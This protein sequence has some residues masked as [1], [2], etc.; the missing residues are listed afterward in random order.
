M[1]DENVKSNTA[2]EP[3]API[4]GGVGG[5]IVLLVI[6]VIGLIYMKRRRRKPL[7]DRVSGEN[8]ALQIVDRNVSLR[9]GGD[10]QEGMYINITRASRQSSSDTDDAI[11]PRVST[12]DISTD[13]S[14]T[15]Y[16]N[17]NILTTV[18]IE[19]LKDYIK[20]K[21]VNEGFHSEYKVIL[22]G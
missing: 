5:G 10:H 9:H 3:V 18:K 20:R 16:N 7:H 11:P 2:T 22:T 4:A 12:K 21:Q 6:V 14:N 15:Y 17:S 19:E 13:E 8:Q 1:E